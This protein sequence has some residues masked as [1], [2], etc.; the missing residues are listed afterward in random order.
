MICILLDLPSI[1]FQLNYSQT[2][3][4]YALKGRL[5]A[6]TAYYKAGACQFYIEKAIFGYENLAFKTG[7]C[8]TEVAFNPTPLKMEF[9]P[10]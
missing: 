3:L 8:L 7:F 1:Q 5:R 6:K 4:Q 2:C 9:W 10:F